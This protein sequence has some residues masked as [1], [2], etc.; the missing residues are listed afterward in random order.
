MEVK[1]ESSARSFKKGL[2]RLCGGNRLRFDVLLLALRS[3]MQPLVS[4]G[5]LLRLRLL[6]A[7]LSVLIEYCLANMLEIDVGSHLTYETCF[8]IL[9]CLISG[10][11][12]RSKNL[13]MLT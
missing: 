4:G 8:K 10:Y 6:Q 11:K 2:L 13:Q 9:L 5:L 3:A 12:V 7:M 1:E